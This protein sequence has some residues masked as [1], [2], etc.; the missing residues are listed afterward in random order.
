MGNQKEEEVGWVGGIRILGPNDSGHVSVLDQTLPFL[1]KTDWS[2]PIV[3]G[4][5]VFLPKTHP[6]TPRQPSSLYHDNL[7]T[8]NTNTVEETVDW[9]SRLSLK[10]LR[11][12]RGK[13]SK[14]HLLLEQRGFDGIFM[15]NKRS[16]YV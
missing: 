13:E 7:W 2:G 16:S 15:T 9:E 14:D 8:D 12:Q 4:L 10:F 3:D 6:I 11:K 1:S 5:G